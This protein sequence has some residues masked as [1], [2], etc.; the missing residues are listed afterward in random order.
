MPANRELER[1]LLQVTRLAGKGTAAVACGHS[2]TAAVLTD[3]TLYTWGTGL[4]GQLGLGPHVTAAVGPTRILA[5]LEGVRWV[6]SNLE[7]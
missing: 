6:T 1:L 4:G 2:Y 7:P 5:G 3:G